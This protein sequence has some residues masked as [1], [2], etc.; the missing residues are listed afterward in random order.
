[1]TAVAGEDLDVEITFADF[2]MLEHGRRFSLEVLSDTLMGLTG[3][4][5]NIG[6]RAFRTSHLIAANLLSSPAFF[7][8]LKPYLFSKHFS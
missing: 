1:M 2:T 5:A 7:K 4:A 8:K 3:G 6:L